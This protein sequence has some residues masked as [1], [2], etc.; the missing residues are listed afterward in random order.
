MM[1]LCVF[2]RSGNLSQLPARF[3]Q[4]AQ[5]G[6]EAAGAANGRAAASSASTS[7]QHLE[8]TPQKSSASR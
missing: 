5:R 6:H 8:H 7:T 1:Q 3:Q 4:A 2:C